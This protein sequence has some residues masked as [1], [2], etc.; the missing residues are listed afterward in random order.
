VKSRG[1]GLENGA[2]FKKAVKHSRRFK[3]IATQ[4]VR[5]AVAGRQLN[6]ITK[7]E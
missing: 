4:V 5:L 6:H 3:Q 2:G 7:P 1:F